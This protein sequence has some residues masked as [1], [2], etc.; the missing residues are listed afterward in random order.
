MPI[1]NECG[2]ET[3]REEMFGL[4]KD[5]RCPACA[6]KR[7]AVYT[8]SPRPVLKVTGNLTKALLGLAIVLFVL[9]SMPA[10]IVV[11]GSEGTFESL[12]LASPPVIWDGQVWRLLTT[13]FLHGNFLHILCN[14]MALWQLGPVLEAYLG[15]WL[16][17]GF[18][19][20]VGMASM[21][22]QLALEPW[23]VVGLSGILFG[24][25]GFL[26]ALRKRKDFAAAAL[27]PSLIQSL[28]FFFFLGIVLDSSGAMA[29]GNWA[30]A[31]GGLVGWLLGYASLHV[32][33]K[34][35]VPL[36]ALVGLGIGLLP[37]WMPWSADF[38]LYQSVKAAQ[39]GNESAARDWYTRSLEA[40]IRPQIF[41]PEEPA[42]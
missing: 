37:T 30:H 40:P 19:A 7:R 28:V 23:P 14:G 34:L 20:L 41:S 6:G 38:C 15:R 9:R 10:K 21:G 5:L 25:F 4:G 24:M 35:L 42:P 11:P 26:W 2:R 29:I 36:T 12:L 22:G 13:C 32:R 3:P 33:R 18:F 1:C 16:Y 27:P 17:L 31:V 8:P 39:V